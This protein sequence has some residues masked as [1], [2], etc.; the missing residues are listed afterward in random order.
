MSEAN[1]NKQGWLKGFL[2]HVGSFLRHLVTVNRGLKLLSV[3]LAV[4][5]WLAITLNTNTETSRTLSQVPVTIDL[6]DTSVGK[7]G[8]SVVSISS[9]SVQVSVKGKRNQVHNLSPEQVTLNYSLNAVTAPGTYELKL[10]AS[11]PSGFGET[12]VTGVNPATVEVRFDTIEKKTVPVTVDYADVQIAKGLVCMPPE[13]AFAEVIVRGPAAD[14][15]KV[16]AAKATL[17]TSSPLS[18]SRDFNVSLVLVDEKGVKVD[19]TYL[20]AEQ[21]QISVVLPVY[22]TKQ[23]PLK[24]IFTGA[25]PQAEL[26]T[27]P[28]SLN[29][30]T[31]ELAGPADKIDALTEVVLATVDLSE[32][33]LDTVKTLPLELPA[34][35]VSMENVTQV[36]FVFRPEGWSQRTFNVKKFAATNVP[37]DKKVKVLSQTIYSVKV[38]GPKANVLKLTNENLTCVVDFLDKSLEKGKWNYPGV[39]QTTGKQVFATTTHQVTVE[40]SD[41]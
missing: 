19:S 23:V 17:S 35:L 22:K 29:H 37:A 36:E 4:F 3:I 15:A 5:I 13:P 12:D 21:E 10:S 8:L 27:L 1:Q 18:T 14:L 28:Y 20:T 30:N 26:D 39:I 16:N 6:T 34:G 41:S 25:L 31:I 7:L 40:V 38:I 24:V 32:L 11:L 9:E 33:S 2:K